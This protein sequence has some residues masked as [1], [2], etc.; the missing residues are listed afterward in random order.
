M[1][2][3]SA[4]DEDMMSRVVPG[5]HFVHFSVCVCACGRVCERS[6][7]HRDISIDSGS[8]RVREGVKGKSTAHTQTTL[9]AYKLVDTSDQVT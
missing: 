5:P 1:R 2:E 4:A 7:G 9:P 3:F 6:I 8:N